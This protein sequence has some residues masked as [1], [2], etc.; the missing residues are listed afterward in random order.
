MSLFSQCELV[1]L[2]PD[3]EHYMVRTHDGE[4]R[5]AIKGL[6]PG[7]KK[8]KKTGDLIVPLNSW[9]SDELKTLHLPWTR[10]AFK[11]R[12]KRKSYEAWLTALSK[13]HDHDL[14]IPPGFGKEPFPFQRGGIAY[15]LERKRV[16]IGDD[17]GL[18]KTIQGLLTIEI[19]DAYPA[20]IV[21]PASNTLTWSDIEIPKCLP[22]R[23]V[24]R[25]NKKTPELKLRMADIIATNY[26]QLVGVRTYK[27]SDGK[28]KRTS[29]TDPTKREV[30]LSPLAEKIKALG[31]KSIILDE[32]HFIKNA[33][34]AAAKVLMELRK[35]V[36]FRILLTGTPMLNKA[37]EFYS[38]L[39]F[40][41]RIDE[42]GGFWFFHNHFC[43]MKETKQGV[44][45]D[46]TTNGIE[47]NEKL[48]ATCYVRRIKKEV[49]TQL[50][51]KTRVTYP[52]EIDN[53]DEYDRAEKDLINWVKERVLRDKAFL[54]S[55]KDL[56]EA[57]RE[58][59]IAEKQEDKAARAERGEIMVRINALKIVS[60]EGKLKQAKDWIDNFLES[61]QK[62][63]VFATHKFVHDC[64]IKA[65]PGCARIL[66]EDSKEVRHQNATRFQ[67]DPKCMLLL[68]GMG[69]SAKSSPAGVG[70]TL[71]AA[72][73]TLF[74]EMGWNPALHSQC[75]D[76]CYRIGQ[77]DNVTCHYFLGKETIEE[78]IANLIEA[79]RALC[80][81]VEDGK[82]SSEDIG[83]LD[84]IWE[85]LKEKT[86]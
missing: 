30:I 7:A 71:T 35:N 82:E 8:D 10:H 63:V 45:A 39:K 86:G 52:V 33:E 78:W 64:I 12:I 43:D 50:P 53:R 1:Y 68:G 47:L 5:E 40:L 4:K 49:L 76:R 57:D 20:L 24:F 29:F 19:A 61:G 48:R 85:M 51:D 84:Q 16:I 46:G 2:A 75:E 25:A 17:M 37:G 38:Y 9:W 60:V 34:T 18:G 21:T 3:K 65:Y 77:K 70:W 80:A 11:T 6:V 66:A 62:L 44:T 41:D 83:I 56:S 23:V 36:R 58:L 14:V 59:A 22:H 79:K 67:T 13:S 72:C 31:I 27:G 28:T 69:A 81:Q 54:E 55:I 42:F 73:N 32:A 15:A 26:E 74:L